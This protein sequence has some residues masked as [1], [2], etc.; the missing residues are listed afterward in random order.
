MGYLVDKFVLQLSL[1]F[2]FFAGNIISHYLEKFHESFL[3]SKL[4]GRTSDDFGKD[5]KKKDNNRK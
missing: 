1:W 2:S 4:F 3:F 5:D